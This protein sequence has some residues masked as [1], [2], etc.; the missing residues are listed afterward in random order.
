[1]QGIALQME[2]WHVN[3]PK[4]GHWI[5]FMIGPMFNIGQAIGKPKSAWSWFSVYP[6]TDLCRPQ[7]NHNRLWDVRVQYKRTFSSLSHAR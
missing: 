2:N 5:E 1:L 4:G 3:G 6:Y 7:P